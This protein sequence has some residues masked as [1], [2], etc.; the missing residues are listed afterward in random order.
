ME[1]FFYAIIKHKKIVLS[2]FLAA[3]IIGAALLPLV[4]VNYN[5]V[6]YLPKDAQSTTAIK[7]IKDEFAA[8]LPNAKVMLA[9]VSIAEALEYKEKISA[10]DGV[11]SVSWLDDVIGLDT[12]KTTPVEF[13]DASILENYYKDNNAL[14]SLTI[15]SGK[16]E[17]TV[18]GLYGLIGENNAAAGEAVNIAKMQEM[19]V[20]E[21]L[22]ALAIV[23]PITIIILI[24]STTSWMEPLLF[25]VCIGIAIIINM[26]TNIVY[27]DISFVT[28][29]V[30][31]VLQL[32]VSMD[33]AIFLLHSFNSYRSSH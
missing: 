32:A 17:D 16:E 11:E 12:L 14:L 8:P 22:N 33:Y 4:S 29:T 30:S 15:E 25:L 23:I 10:I 18:D 19:S 27:K 26:G 9:D 6:D 7:I 1:R 13:L 20:S 3:A 21:I 5:I 28:L 2:V 31:P 24:I